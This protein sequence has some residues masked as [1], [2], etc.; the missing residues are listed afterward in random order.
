MVINQTTHGCDHE[1]LPTC[2]IGEYPLMPFWPTKTHTSRNDSVFMKELP[3][4]PMAFRVDPSSLYT[5]RWIQ[6]LY[7]Q[8]VAS[9]GQIK[10]WAF[11][12][13][14]LLHWVHSAACASQAHSAVWYTYAWES[15]RSV[16]VTPLEPFVTPSRPQI[17]SKLIMWLDSTW[18]QFD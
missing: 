3:R 8:T 10:I 7:K 12:Q 18:L 9:W 1:H 14:F 15:R 13:R 2:S 11:W 17:D 4:A 6:Q 16:N 5:A